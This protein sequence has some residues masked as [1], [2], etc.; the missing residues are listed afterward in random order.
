MVRPNPPLLRDHFFQEGR[1]TEI[2]AMFIL[3][4]ATQMLS[5]EPNLVKVKSPVT[6]ASLLS[7]LC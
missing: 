6:S 2:Q 1:L 4:R 5:R 3:E 7:L